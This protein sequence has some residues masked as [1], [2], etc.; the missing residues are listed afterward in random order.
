MI[1]GVGVGCGNKMDDVLP[2]FS[3]ACKEPGVKKGM[4]GIGDFLF[5]GSNLCL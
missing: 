3:S 4:V 1:R 5:Q 2:K